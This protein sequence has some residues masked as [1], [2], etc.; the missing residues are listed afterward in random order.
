MRPADWRV[1]MRLRMRFKRRLMSVC[2][3][4][5]DNEGGDRGGGDEMGEVHHWKLAVGC[6]EKFEVIFAGLDRREVESE[7][8][9]FFERSGSSGGEL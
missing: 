7:A 2:G 4:E 5:G 8:D 9:V 1:D 3:S 6:N